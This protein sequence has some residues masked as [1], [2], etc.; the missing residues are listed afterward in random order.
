LAAAVAF[1]TSINLSQRPDLL[2]SRTI[3]ERRLFAGSLT[4]NKGAAG[5]PALEL[6]CIF[7]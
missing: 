1:A 6:D 3:R 5:A 4:E 2:L 7:K